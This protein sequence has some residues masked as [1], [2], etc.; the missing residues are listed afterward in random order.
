MAETVKLGLP[1]VEASQAQKHVT[2]NEAL[3]RVD[4]LTQLTLA[5][6][7]LTV[8]PGAPGEGGAY[9]VPEGA[10][11]AWS[12]QDGQVALWLNGG[13]AFLAPQTGWRAWVADE[14]AP[15]VFDG[16]DWLSGT[17]AVSPNGAALTQRVIEIDHI[18]AAGP[19]SDTA[20]VIPAQSLVYGVT[21][22]V[23]SEITGT[24]T[25]WRLGIGGVSEDRYGSGLGLL[26][27]SW[28]RGLTSS[29]LAYYADTAL[30]LT[31]EAGDFAGGAVRLA[32]HIGE[33]TLPRG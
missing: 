27:D 11:G 2:V 1:L 17:G 22:R 32:V 8:A 9:A 29:P 10:G 13:W 14:G 15:A 6:R 24:A 18:L 5:S 23:L 21:G 4:A 19:S 26:Q 33:L 3:A 16:V 31:A 12:G 7:S 30:T 25:A 28:V 20:N